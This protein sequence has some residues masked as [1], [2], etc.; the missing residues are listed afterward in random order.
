MTPAPDRPKEYIPQ[1]SPVEMHD[2]DPRRHELDDTRRYPE[3]P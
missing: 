2:A 3:L 1:R